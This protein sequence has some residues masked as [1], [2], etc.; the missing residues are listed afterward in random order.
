MTIFRLLCS[1]TCVSMMLAGV[2]YLIFLGSRTTRRVETGD[3]RP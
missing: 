1:A 3:R 2:A